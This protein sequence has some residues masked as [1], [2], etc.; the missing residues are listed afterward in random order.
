MVDPAWSQ[1]PFLIAASMDHSTATAAFRP[2]PAPPIFWCLPFALLLLAIATFP[3]SRRLAHW[4]EHNQNKLLVG[5]ALGVVVLFHY[6]TRGYGAHDAS[7]PGHVSPPG[8]P[9]LVSV[10]RH[11]VLAEYLPFIVLLFSLYVI[12]G[13]LKLKG[14][15]R[16]TPLNNTIFLAVGSGLASFIGT[17]GASMLLIRP[18]LQTNRERRFV[19]H[20]VIFFIFLVSNI[21]GSLLPIGD[22]PLFLG[23]LRGVPFLWTLNLFTIWAILVGCLLGLYFLWDSRA[24]RRE[25]PEAKS[26]DI[27]MREPLR[28]AGSINLIWLLGV[29]LSVAL[30]VPGRR[31]P[32]TPFV[33]GEYVREAAMLGLAALSLVTT[34]Q[35]LRKD[36][37]FNYQAILEVAALFLGIFITMQVPIEILQA[38]GKE[39][40]LSDP[41]HFFWASGLLSSVL[42]NAPTYVVFFEAAR[43]LPQPAGAELVALISGEPIRNDLLRAISLG[44]VFMGANTYIGNGPNFM[45]KSIAESR[46]VAMPG[47]FG[48]MRYSLTI[49]IPL[50]VLVTWL[51]GR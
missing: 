18:L 16:A 31:L 48:Y 10:L 42:D 7:F 23:Y 14:D 44:A 41:A 43:S 40:G 27:Q 17:T 3:L 15:L 9:T 29:V 47:F 13:G 12:S 34:P 35:G 1:V 28:L 46:G 45:V 50:F 26:L 8:W 39:L 5:L 49:L 33:V 30:I 4:W 2:V 38:H 37:E 19:V 22:P 51:L 24:Y 25:A 21:G 32:G 6:A 20:T 11:A 36:V